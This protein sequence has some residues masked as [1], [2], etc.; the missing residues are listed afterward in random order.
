VGM[1]GG[2]RGVKKC[3]SVG[4]SVWGTGVG[5]GVSRSARWSVEGRRGEGGRV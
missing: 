1:G 4:G 2:E 5:A 3:H